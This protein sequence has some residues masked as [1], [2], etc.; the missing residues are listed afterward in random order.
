MSLAERFETLVWYAADPGRRSALLPL[1]RAKLAP[2][3]KERSKDEAVRLCEAHAVS[4]SE[5][6]A[7]LA[8]DHQPVSLHEAFAQTM[9]DAERRCAAAPVRMG[10]PG[11]LDLLFNLAEAAQATSAVETGV[12]YGWSSLALLLSLSC[13]ESRLISTDMPYAKAGNEP[14]VGVAVPETLSAGWTLIRQADRSGLPRALRMAGPI[15]L[16][17]YDSDKSYAGRRFAYPRLWAALKPG[18]Y[19]ISDDIGDNVAFH[20]F[21]ADVGAPATIVATQDKFVGVI[22]KPG[23]ADGAAMASVP[24]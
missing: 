2:H 12:A 13:R 21:A 7:R 11:D 19:F 3:P 10:G 5:A 1:I 24:H 23:G 17:H 18:G 6:L 20:E 16:C 4:T 14:Y 9:A 8:P 15:D 22:R